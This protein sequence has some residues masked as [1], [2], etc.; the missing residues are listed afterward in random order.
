ML[1]QLPK[2]LI[3][4]FSLFQLV[5]VSF[6]QFSIPPL[7][8]GVSSSVPLPLLPLLVDVLN[9]RQ[10]SASLYLLSVSKGHFIALFPSLSHN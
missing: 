8:F 10:L 1:K 4:R 5:A 6:I 2:L 3:L 9:K 7:L